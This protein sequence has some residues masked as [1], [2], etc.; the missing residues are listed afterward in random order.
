M[1]EFLQT[2]EDAAWVDGVERLPPDQ[3]AI[4]IATL[5]EDKPSIRPVVNE[6]D[7]GDPG[8]R[9][10]SN[11]VEVVALDESAG[12]VAASPGAA[13]GASVVP[14]RLTGICTGVCMSLVFSIVINIS[15]YGNIV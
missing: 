3:R 7:A 11:V 6:D 12:A 10:S 14:P 9:L 4:A 15:L 8:G 1:D 5:A 13:G 2:K